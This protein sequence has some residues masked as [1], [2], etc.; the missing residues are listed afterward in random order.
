MEIEQWRA[1]RNET[2][3][4]RKDRLL[5][6]LLK[7]NEKFIIANVQRLMRRGIISPISTISD[8]PLDDMVQAGRIGYVAALDKFDPAKGAFPPHAKAWIRHEVQK[9][10]HN[11]M[12]IR[13]PRG[14]GLSKDT[15]RKMDQ[16]RAREGRE[17]EAEDLGIKDE[18][19]TNWRTEP[20]VMSYYTPVNV[21]Y[22]KTGRMESG[23]ETNVDSNPYSQLADE[24]TPNPEDLTGLK[25]LHASI[26]R[27]PDL[28]RRVIEGKYF[29]DKSLS[30]LLA[31]LKIACST[32]YEIE[33]QAL[34]MLREEV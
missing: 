34:V 30:T 26:E 9:A 5:R 10:A 22:M 20:V 32:F 15:L 1:Y 3:P 11:E 14:S 13:K 16:V 6:K 2:N 12:T 24:E 19:L 21:D 4:A 8:L 29:S 23:F 17:P 18:K 33:K 27:L 7:D 31:E 25:G 28:H